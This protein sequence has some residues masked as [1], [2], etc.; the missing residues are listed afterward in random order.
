MTRR[1]WSSLS[2]DER[3]QIHGAPP[4][5]GQVGGASLIGR[6]LVEPISA[7]LRFT[8]K[9]ITEQAQRRFG[10]VMWHTPGVKDVVSRDMP[11]RHEP[12]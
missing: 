7:I 6:Q 10:L 4:E 2:L 8:A 9:W 5:I 11:E 1:K 12:S 3:V